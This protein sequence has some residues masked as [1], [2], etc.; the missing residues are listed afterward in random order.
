M[1][2]TTKPNCHVLRMNKF[3]VNVNP[4]RQRVSRISVITCYLLKFTSQMSVLKP[5]NINMFHAIIKGMKRTTFF[6]FSNIIIIDRALSKCY[7]MNCNHKR[8]HPWMPECLNTQ[9]NLSMGAWLL[10][11]HKH[12]YFPELAKL[13]R[14]L[15]C[16]DFSIATAERSFNISR[17]LI[18]Y[19][20]LVAKNIQIRR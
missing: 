8:W 11:D 16:L 5:I 12:N 17:R 14:I 6:T 7:L 15:E 10:T 13:L 1:S 3:K 4:T 18:M 20:R 9:I 19:I 2:W